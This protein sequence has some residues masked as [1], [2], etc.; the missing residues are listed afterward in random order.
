MNIRVETLSSSRLS[1]AIADL[2]RLR[3]TVFREWPYL[4][5][6]DLGYEASYLETF[7]RSER[8]IIV[9]AIDPADEKI[10]GA[11]TAAPL[12]EH[13][14]AFG[15][16]F[17]ENGRDPE[18]YFYCGESVLLKTYRGKGIGHAFFDARESY[19]SSLNENGQ[20]VFK[21]ITFCAVVRADDDPRRPSGYRPLDPF[22]SGRGYRKIQGLVGYYD[23]REIGQSIETRKAM[24]FWIRALS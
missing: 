10:V 13:T 16:L 6:G 5:D 15:A 12:A 4:Y 18:H 2:A 7:I 19:A 24:Q 11:A 14:D 8:S 9:V 21:H 17:C 20:S 22:W 3:M 1:D 23:W